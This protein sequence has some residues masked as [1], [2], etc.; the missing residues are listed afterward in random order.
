MV[1]VRL[2]LH[3][4]LSY[5]TDLPALDFSHFTMA[6]LS[7]SNGHGKSALLDAITWAIWGEARKAGGTSRPHQGLV[8]SGATDMWVVLDFDHEGQRYRVRRGYHVQG[9]GGR[10]ELDLFVW[11]SDRADYRVLTL[12][13]AA[14]TDQRI[15][16][17][18]RMDHDT[19]VNSA[20]L[21]QGRDDEFTRRRPAERKQVLTEILGL[22]RYDALRDLARQKLQAADQDIATS[23]RL[24]ASLSEQLADA[25][26]VRQKLDAVTV[27]LAELSAR[28]SSQ[29][30]ELAALREALAEDAL[31]RQRL[32]AAQAAIRELAPEIDGLR[33]ELA[34]GQAQQTET[35]AL[36]SEREAVS[37]ACQRLAALDAERG[38]VEQ[39]LS[40]YRE[41]DTEQHRLTTEIRAQTREAEADLRRWQEQI[42]EAE[43]RRA[44]A[45]TVLARRE[46]IRQQIEAQEHLRERLQQAEANEARFRSLEEQAREAERRVERARLAIESQLQQVVEQR[47]RLRQRADAEADLRKQLDQAR[48]A[49]AAAE[50]A[51]QLAVATERRKAGVEL[52][53]ERLRGL[54]AQ[55]DER[56][57]DLDQHRAILTSGGGQCP[58]CGQ[59]LAADR[60]DAVLDRFALRREELLGEQRELKATGRQLKDDLAALEQRLRELS[61]QELR[62]V[63]LARDLARAEQQLAEATEAAAEWARVEEQARDLKAR[64][65][66]GDYG[67]PD[68]EDLRRLRREMAALDYLPEQVAGLRR[69]MAAGREVERERVL[70]EQA[71]KQALEAAAFLP[72]ATTAV[73]ELEDKLRHH[74]VAKAERERLAQVDIELEAITW[75]DAD[76]SRLDQARRELVGAPLQWQ[77]IEDAAARL[78]DLVQRVSVLTGRLATRERNLRERER[79]REEL[80][81]NLLDAPAER[82]RMEHL[83]ET[84]TDLAA[85][86]A[87]QRELR[88]QLQEATARQERWRQELADTRARLVDVRHRRELM[89]H[90]QT[91][92][93]RDGIPALIIE[94]AVPEIEQ[95]A[96][97]LL[98]RLTGYRMSLSVR[99][100]RP[101]QGGGDRETLDLDISDELGTRSYENYSGGEAF[102]VNFALR[103]ALSQLLTRRV[104]ARLRTL[105]IDEGF[106]TQD[107][108]GLDQL[109]EAIHAVREHYDLVLVVTHLTAL[110]ER[111]PTRIEVSKEPDTGSHFVLV[112]A[113]EAN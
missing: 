67:G 3:N 106:G 49:L 66:A 86:M 7:G 107:D 61:A 113:A 64:L 100:Q 16:S 96:N 53:F 14:A 36:L 76:L 31:R 33:R 41:L 101:L 110:K 34:Q 17:L 37:A 90:L 97:E 99:L 47:T 27:S 45:E 82:R 59:V 6:C 46:R 11:D 42:Q 5:G 91:A 105:I 74:A 26:E 72:G 62:A 21:K 39:A 111:F 2:Q 12:P 92:F 109:V 22:S 24:A 40:R 87:A 23:E 35:E 93:G 108:D 98:G 29:T 48:E 30:A 20:F 89:D 50:Q 60:R 80:T 15:R 8:R 44:E 4:F 77:R 68:A 73:A 85:Q 19:F 70:L 88:G 57:A 43:G 103:L 52:E 28:H 81:A 13:T 38:Q 79:E 65:G 51:E 94:N 18:L 71:E 83:T 69:A 112:G 58:V 1:P 10:L 84:V 55:V 56:L 102:R 9:R 78:P 32:D 95:V 25:D 75:R 63:K 104:G 54:H